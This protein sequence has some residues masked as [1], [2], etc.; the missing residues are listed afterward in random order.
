MDTEF[1]MQAL[2]DAELYKA[3]VEH[4]RKFYHVSYADYDKNYPDRIAFYPTERSLKTWESDYKALQD[5]F[6]YGDK[7]PFRQL[8]LRIEE[9]QRRFREVDIK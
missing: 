9:L 7:L 6:V 3:I 2:A 5:A 8:L 4:R 1:G